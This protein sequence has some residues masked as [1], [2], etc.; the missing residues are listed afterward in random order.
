MK[1]HKPTVRY[2]RGLVTGPTIPLGRTEDFD[3][4]VFTLGLQQRQL[5]VDPSAAGVAPVLTVAPETADV[6]GVAAAA[7]GCT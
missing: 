2:N 3:L 6:V 5:T 1:N 4:E 7:I